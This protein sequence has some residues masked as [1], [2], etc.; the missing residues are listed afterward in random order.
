MPPIDKADRRDRHRRKAIDSKYQNV[1][2]R[3]L[4]AGDS[5]A[6]FEAERKTRLQGKPVR[7][8]KRKK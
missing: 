2:Y 7:K 3:T 5:L 1:R 8:M 4:R 6:T